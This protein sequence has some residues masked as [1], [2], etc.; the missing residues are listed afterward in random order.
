MARK[1]A[2]KAKPAVEKQE[3]RRRP[4]EY[5]N[6]LGLR[7][8]DEIAGGGKL[9]EICAAPGMPDKSTCYRWLGRHEDFAAMHG[10]ARAARAVVRSDKI[11]EIIE[12]V[13]A[14]NIEPNAGRVAID[15]HRWQASKEDPK[16]FGEKATL[17]VNANTTPNAE[18]ISETAQWLEGLLRSSE[19]NE[20]KTSL[21]R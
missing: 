5:T 12:G 17:N 14:G 15:A 1:P 2:A 3:V 19:D 8:C 7:I 9:A 6:E 4:V 21:P 10:R 20:A 16:G 13:L 11:D 18:S